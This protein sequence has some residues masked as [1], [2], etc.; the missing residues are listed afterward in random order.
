LA[1]DRELRAAIPLHSREPLL[2][3]PDMA[4]HRA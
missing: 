4:R 1:T 2:S 3:E